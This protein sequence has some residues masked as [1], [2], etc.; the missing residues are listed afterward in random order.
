MKFLPPL[1]LSLLFVLPAVAVDHLTVV[2]DSLTKEYEVTFPGLPGLVEGIDATNPGA[3]NWAEILH[4]Y[5]NGA[6]DSGVFKN[7]LFTNRWTDL[8][9]LGHEYNWAVPGA[10]ARTIRN[11]LL[12]PNGTEITGDTDFATLAVFAPNWKQTGT[13]LSAQVSSTSTAAIIW[14]GGNDLRFG[15]TDPAA[16]VNGEAIRYET[17]YTGNGTGAGNP[18]PLMDSMK[19]SIQ[20]IAQYVRAANP[21]LPIAVCAVPH[22]GCTP[23]VQ[24]QWPTDATRTGRITTAL[25]TLNADLKTW[26][27]G[28]L[29]GAWI[30]TYSVTKDLITKSPVIGGVTFINGSDEKTASDPTSA[31]NRYVFSHDGFHPTTTMHAVIAQ[32]VITALAA[33]YPAKFGTV[34]PL[35]DREILATVL[36]IP[37]N[38]GFNEF[39][40]TSGAPAGARGPEQDA[41]G[42]G[43]TNLVE[44]AL[45]G[46]NP[47]AEGSLVLPVSGR[48]TV[49]GN[50]VLTLKWTPRFASNVY[51]SLVCQSS[52]DLSTWT[53]VPAGQVTANADSSMTARVP[54][55]AAGPLFLRVKVTSTP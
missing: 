3:R 46:N 41:D 32:K 33:K 20:A 15:S 47:Y 27:E 11:F 18:Q 10:T 6:F 5:R 13:L 37:V 42:D 40:A 29:G 23:D 49:A 43:L 50:E 44:F 51:A 53:D 35:T 30:D 1:F 31:H 19:A 24:S 36:G 54:Q 12:D 48:E 25:D 8:R 28:T 17:I 4:T 34:A 9:L 39:M 55:P 7:S 38:T 16:M 22:V 26:T 14:C 52:A 2:G 45:A 21:T